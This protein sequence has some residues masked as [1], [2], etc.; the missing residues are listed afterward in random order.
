MHSVAYKLINPTSSGCGNKVCLGYGSRYMCN[1]SL[2]NSSF[3][4]GDIILY[5]NMTATFCYVDMTDVS[6]GCGAMA[7]ISFLV[8]A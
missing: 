7:H 3:D 2:I 5:G 6:S 4:Y 8:M 1:G